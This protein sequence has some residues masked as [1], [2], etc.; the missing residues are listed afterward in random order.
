MCSGM[1]GP[2]EST[3]EV[4]LFGES[5]GNFGSMRSRKTDEYDVLF[6][7]FENLCKSNVRGAEVYP[8]CSEGPITTNYY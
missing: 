8:H 3:T 1:S 7:T 6:C 2:A 5:I 4:K